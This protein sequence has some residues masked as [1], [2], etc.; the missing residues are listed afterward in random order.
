[1]ENPNRK[2]LRPTG[3]LRIA[4]A[5][6]LLALLTCACTE[7]TPPAPSETTAQT[8]VPEQSVPTTEP[9]TEP[10]TQPTEAIL[11]GWQ[12]IDGLRYYYGE[13]GTPYIGWLLTEKGTYYLN[14]D[15]S[16]RTGWADIGDQ[17][18]YFGQDG[19]MHTGWL[20]ED[21][22]KYYFLEGGAMALGW[23]HIGASQYYFG[24]DGVMYTGWLY[25]G[26]YAYYLGAEGAAAVGKTKIDGKTYYFSPSG[27]HIILVNRWNPVPEDYVLNLVDTERDKK[28]SAS[29][30]NALEQ[31]LSDCRKAGCNPVLYSGYRSEKTQERLYKNKIQEFRNKG[32][33][34]AEAEERAA[35]IVAVPGTSEH[36]LGLAVDIVDNSNWKLNSS[37]EKTKTQ[38]WLMEHCWEYGFILRYPTDKSNL[39][40]IGYEPWHYRYV[41]KEAALSMRDSGLCLEEYIRTLNTKEVPQEMQQEA[42]IAAS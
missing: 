2:K 28:V 38:Q 12:E 42:A 18:Y 41:G 7:Q 29:C 40:G 23:T 36:H 30:I 3:L 35:K 26:E 33:G 24:T 16:A 10:A 27:I 21:G 22:R 4:A 34:R 6:T 37:Q 17:T 31:M 15:G 5:V 39:T 14:A 8:T 11:T 19:T 20:E 25:R 9:V 32:Y 1:M 13:D